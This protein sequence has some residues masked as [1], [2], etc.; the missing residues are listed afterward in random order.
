LF[1]LFS[2]GRASPPINLHG[3]SIDDP[4][5]R[6]SVVNLHAIKGWRGQ[7]K[8]TRTVAVMRRFTGNKFYLYCSNTS[9]LLR[10]T[11]EGRYIA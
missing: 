7:S 10:N 4:H 2:I 5:G 3:S 6:C 1:R 9:N 8:G 11:R